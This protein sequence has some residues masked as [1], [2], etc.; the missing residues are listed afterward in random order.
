[1][2]G[3]IALLLSLHSLSRMLQRHLKDRR[4][5]FPARLPVATVRAGTAL[6]VLLGAMTIHWGEV[7]SSLLL[8]LLGVLALAASVVLQLRNGPLALAAEGAALLS[9]PALCELPWLC[10]LPVLVYFGLTLDMRLEGGQALAAGKSEPA[11]GHAASLAYSL[12]V[13]AGVALAVAKE[14]L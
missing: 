3:A 4:R 14:V 13:L 6:L 9:V 7:E 1:M 5:I 12:L 11:S 2:I 8:P 10:A